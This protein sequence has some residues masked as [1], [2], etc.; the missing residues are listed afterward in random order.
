MVHGRK[1]QPHPSESAEEWILFPTTPSPAVNVS[2]LGNGE[3]A[4]PVFPICYRAVLDNP[5]QKERDLI[6]RC[7]EGIVMP[8]GTLR[9]QFE[10]EI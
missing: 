4:K 2:R 1:V 7:I 3:A 8:V 6:S 5:G 9:F 10:G